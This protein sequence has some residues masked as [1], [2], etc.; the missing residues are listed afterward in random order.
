VLRVE[1]GH[2]VRHTVKLGVTAAG[3]AEVL[4]GLQQGEV[5]LATTPTVAVGARVRADVAAPAK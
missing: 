3:F 5:V 1:G 4:E 2:A